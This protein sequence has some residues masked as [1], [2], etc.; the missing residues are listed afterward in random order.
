MALS[1]C[2]GD[3]SS[4]TEPGG[5]PD[6]EPGQ[7]SRGACSC[8]DGG[9]GKILHDLCTGEA[10]TACLCGEVIE[11]AVAESPCAAS[12]RCFSD[13]DCDACACNPIVVSEPLN[14]DGEILDM[15]GDGAGGVLL[16][17]GR[18]PWVV[19]ITPEGMLTP[20]QIDFDLSG[21]S[22]LWLAPDASIVALGTVG[23]DSAAHV[24]FW[25]MNDQ[26][27]SLGSG[28]WSPHAEGG[29][30]RA[31]AVR[32]DGRLALLSIS[33]EAPGVILGD[34]GLT[35]ALG[36]LDTETETVETIGTTD[37]GTDPLASGRANG[38]EIADFAVGPDGDYFV[39]GNLHG[40]Q[41][42]DAAWRVRFGADG[43]PAAELFDRSFDL[44]R[45]RPQLASSEAGVFQ[46]WTWRFS[47]SEP[48][49]NYF[50]ALTPELAESWRATSEGPEIVY[51]PVTALTA[52]PDG[53]VVGATEMDQHVLRRF[54]FDGS[55]LV[56]PVMLE[57][58]V[59]RMAVVGPYQLAVVE[60]LPMYQ[61]IAYRRLRWVTLEPLAVQ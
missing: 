27:A 7:L 43:V 33:N 57:E 53:V 52:L 29:S 9:N 19:R 25:R 4:S 49:T 34:R 54:A 15:I 21:A 23:L 37:F 26:G 42:L 47:D 5:G 24:E 40:Y 39:V 44:T 31:V 2:N 11:C 48:Y 60:S 59:E 17:V 51:Q 1:A 41:R 61:N 14:L 20:L 50:A 32:P 28:S 18:D 10:V 58:P 45:T 55:S 46:A 6:C 12:Q 56:L 22:R 3:E 30:L 36:V 38:R 35:T 8:P 13:G 16:L